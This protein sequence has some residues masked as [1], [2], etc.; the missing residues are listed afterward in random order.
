MIG[1]DPVLARMKG[2]LGDWESA[3]DRRLIFLTCYELMT[4][5]I[6]AAIE[7]K[8][9]EDVNWV[10]TLMENFAGYYFHALEVY[11]DDQANSPAAWRI[12][13]KAAHDPRTHVLQNLV[14]GV[15]AHINYDLVLALSDLLAPEW[16]QLSTEQR[17]MRY[18]DHCHVNDIINQTINAVQDQVIDRF[19]PWFAVVDK[20]LGPVDEWMTSLLISEWREEVWKYATRII[21]PAEFMDKQTV[22]QHVERVSIQ[23]AQEI[24]GKGGLPELIDFL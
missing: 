19:E 1:K 13:F 16:P 22:I 24:L 23:R 21:D 17:K 18:R 12:A 15:N 8:D 10:A 20:V 4:Q 2:L 9:F 5:N 11:E 14:L 7:A 6:L 3:K